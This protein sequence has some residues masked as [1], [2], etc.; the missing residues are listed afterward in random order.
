MS[1]HS[2]WETTKRQKEATDKKR[3]ALFS[4]L[5]R[6][7]TVSAREN[8]GNIE[9]NFN[10]RMFIEKAKDANMPKD[11]IERAIKKGIGELK[12]EI[13]EKILYEAIGPGNI[14][15]VI[16]SLTDNKNRAVSE[17]RH[18]F[19]K[20]NG[21]LVSKNSVMWQ[22]KRK[23]VIKIKNYESKIKNLDLDIEE[24]ELNLIDY[25]AEDIKKDGKDLIVYT[26]EKE[27]QK[28]KEKIE[29]NNLKIEDA[30]IEF[31]P[32]ETKKVTGQKEIEKVRNIFDALN[33]CEDVNNF[34]TNVI[35]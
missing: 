5:A 6:N 7:I 19:S 9:T 16:E 23:G 8:G 25:E 33:E 17:I 4:R 32:K 1:G 34:Y 28:I 30:G 35:L 27:L 10:L 26:K 3:S 12:G 15:F 2:K 29:K 22:F 14:F 20:Y 21:S 24:F 18:I 31:L 13:I 11:K